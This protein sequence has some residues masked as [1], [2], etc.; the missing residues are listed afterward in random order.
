MGLADEREAVLELAM[1]KFTTDRGR[2]SGLGIFFSSRMVDRFSLQSGAVDFEYETG[3]GEEWSINPRA[4]EKGTS[5][6][7]TLGNASVRN[8]SE[9]FDAFSDGTMLGFSKTVIPIR[10][11]AYGKEQLVSRS[12]AK[13]VL[14]RV[15]QFTQVTFD[16]SEVK[17]IGQ[18]FADEIFRVFAKANPELVMKEVHT[19]RSVAQ[20][21]AAVRQEARRQANVERKMVPLAQRKLRK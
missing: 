19:N 21:I 13:R 18:G 4:S 10:L 17:E 2:H 16:F 3:Q 6:F 12:Q 20:M 7:L 1:G 15:D 8:T 14:A 5:V 11:A 9:I